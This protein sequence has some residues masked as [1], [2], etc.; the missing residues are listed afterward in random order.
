MNEQKARE[1]LGEDITEDGVSNGINYVYYKK[2]DDCVTLDGSF[3]VDY[4]E[5]LVWWM[6]NMKDPCEV[7]HGTGKVEVQ[8]DRPG[9]PDL[10]YEKVCECK[11]K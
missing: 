7:C 4:L 10:V 5:A 1:I 2:G 8:E 6:K 9:Q 11:I 3:G